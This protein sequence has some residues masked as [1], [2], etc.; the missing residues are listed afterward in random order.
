MMLKIDSSQ[1]F[2]QL[3]IL[4]FVFAPY[5]WLGGLSPRVVILWYLISNAGVLLDN[6][7]VI[8]VN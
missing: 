6:N 8:R 7:I 1:H 4:N 5:H 2:P 3:F